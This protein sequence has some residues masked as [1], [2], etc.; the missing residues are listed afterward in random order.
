MAAKFKSKTRMKKEN[1]NF[2]SYFGRIQ[3]Q[4]CEK[5]QQVKIFFEKYQ[6]GF[7]DFKSGKKALQNCSMKG[8][9]SSDLS[10]TSKYINTKSSEKDG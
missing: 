5:F 6:E 8:K 1:L 7:A 4:K 2:L 3:L 10:L 9:M